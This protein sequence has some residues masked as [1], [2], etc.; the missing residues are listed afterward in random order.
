MVHVSAGTDTY[1]RVKTVSGTSIV[2]KFA[3]LQ[4]LPFYPLQSFYFIGT[5][6][7]E[8]TGVPFLASWTSVAIRGIPLATVDTT[9]VA[10]AY[11][12]GVFGALV[13]VG[14]MVIVPGIMHLTGEHLDEF[15]MIAT[16]ALLI[17]F[18][19]GVVGGLL[20]YALPLTPRREREIR[21]YC[22]ELLGVAADPARIESEASASLATYVDEQ[23]QSA[24]NSRVQLIRQLIATRAMIAQAIDSD[25]METKTDELLERLR[26]A[27]RFTA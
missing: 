23:H 14:F 2:T 4:F 3:M 27:E 16:R 18:V 26:D 17:S 12:R 13:I 5:G 7:T 1:G 24:D 21:Q 8:R 10:I 22:G 15:A 6:P 9:S 11:A 19:T 20:T 25:R